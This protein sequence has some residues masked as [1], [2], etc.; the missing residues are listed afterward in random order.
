MYGP[1]GYGS[2]SSPL[3]VQWKYIDAVTAVKRYVFVRIGTDRHR[4]VLSV[5][6]TA[7]NEGVRA[8]TID[9]LDCRDNHEVR[10]TDDMERRYALM[11]M[12]ELVSLSHV[13]GLLSDVCTAEAEAIRQEEHAH[14]PG[15]PR[16]GH[17]ARSSLSDPWDDAAECMAAASVNVNV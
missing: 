16:I 5:A 9:G 3:G 17:Y 8:M 7:I 15:C 13:L 12:I 10:Y 4:V 1:N 2:V 6:P 11:R 14:G